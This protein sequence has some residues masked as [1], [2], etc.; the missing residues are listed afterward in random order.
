MSQKT[1]LAK[2]VT[3]SVSWKQVQII[4]KVNGK[5]LGYNT[6][7]H[8]DKNGQL[9][10]D[11]TDAAKSWLPVSSDYPAVTS[12]DLT[13][14]G[15]EKV[16]SFNQQHNQQDAAVVVE[17]SAKRNVSG[18]EVDVYYF[19]ANT[20][21]SRT[22][23]VNEVIRYRYKDTGKTAA[24]DFVAKPLSF[25]QTGYKDMVTNVVVW[26][27]Q[28]SPA[29]EFKAVTSPKINGYTPDKSVIQAQRVDH[30][31]PDLEFLVL[32]SKKA[33]PTKPTEPTQPTQ[34]TKPTV[35]T[36]PTQPTV[37][38]SPT[39]PTQPT[40]PTQPTNP[41]QPTQLTAPTEPQTPKQPNR[42]LPQ[43]GRKGNMGIVA[44]VLAAMFAGSL[45]LGFKKC[46]N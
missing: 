18:G 15:Y 14:F 4:D 25:T 27:G 22:V 30:N 11:T 45:G 28:W 34:P 38:T 12:P 19:H 9:T 10:V 36:Q 44:A 5:V 35:P 7:G 16:P 2:K 1:A 43:T 21:Q 46:R 24:P 33:Q 32:Y 8:K 20:P 13:S 26:N 17:K 40:R 41:V 29:Q 6:T 3:Q 42:Q 37:P 23:K 39:K 31:S